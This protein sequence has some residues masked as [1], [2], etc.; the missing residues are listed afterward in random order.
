[1]LD[2]YSID[3]Q[4]S[5][6]LLSLDLGMNE[7]PKHLPADERRAVTVET[8]INLAAEKNPS[9]ITTKA[10]AER[11]GLTQGAIF[12]H[13]PN[14]EAILQAVMTWVSKR[15]LER[16]DKAIK[17]IDSPAAA[18]EAVFLA[19]IDFIAEHPGVPRMLFAELQ[20]KEQS[21]PKKMVQTL[22][23]HYRERVRGLLEKGKAQGEF[24]AELNVDAAVMLFVGSIQGL[25]M[26]SLLLDDVAGIRSDAP[27]IFAIYRHGLG[28]A[29]P[30]THDKD[31]IL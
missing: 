1:L 24:S 31:A 15:L 12:R 19:H 27:D 30:T 6:Q 29:D 4:D 5:N 26:Q 28:V 9:E 18:L 14:K 3:Y 10:I 17:G 7:R 23:M 16:V 20:R 25:V 21:L 13:F 8:V 2:R 22:L 11:M